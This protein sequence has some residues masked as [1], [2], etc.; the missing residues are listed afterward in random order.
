MAQAGISKLEHSADPKQ[1]TL[2]KL[3]EALGGTLIIQAE[4]NGR[5]IDLSHGSAASTVHDE[6]PEMVPS[7]EARQQRNP[8]LCRTR[9]AHH[10]RCASGASLFG[11]RSL[12]A[13]SGCCEPDSSGFPA[14]EPLDSLLDRPSPHQRSLGRTIGIA[15]GEPGRTATATRRD[16]RRTRIDRRRR[17]PTP[18]TDGP[19]RNPRQS[20]SHGAP[21]ARVR[22][23]VLLRREG[24]GL[25]GVIVIL[26][27]T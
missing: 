10:H 12:D 7:G 26:T 21:R 11:E 16:D 2:R 24:E 22:A 20:A 4:I 15:T 14:G 25:D 23:S 9:R 13:L 8:G 3:I 19:H 18:R 27:L 5:T 1:S 17:Q 6:S